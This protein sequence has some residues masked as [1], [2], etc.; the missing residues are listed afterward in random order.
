MAQPDVTSAKW[1]GHPKSF[2]TGRLTGQ[3]SVIVMHTTEGS[4]GASSA[5]NGAAYDKTRTDGTSTH[6]F[7]DSDSTVQEVEIKDE[8]HAAREHGNNI[9]IQIE[10]CGKAGQT[11]AQWDDAVSK[12]TMERV[13]QLVVELRKKGNYPLVRLNKAQL[14]SAAYDKGAVHGI[15]GH[16]D[17]TYAF[18]EDNG[19]HTDPGPDFPWEALFK[20]VTALEGGNALKTAPKIA[21]KVGSDTLMLPEFKEGDNDRDFGGRDHIWRMQGIIGA[22]RDHDWGPQTTTALAAFLKKPAADCKK[23]TADIYINLYGLDG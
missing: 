5:E 10:I 19:T 20:R 18:P 3:P 11:T 7:V 6:F 9:G 8:A 21:V 16:V 22:T 1:V 14:R 17:I 13:A 4:E 15:C 12:A 2:T 23:L